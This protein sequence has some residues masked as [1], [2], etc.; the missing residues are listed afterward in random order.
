MNYFEIFDIPVSYGIDEQKITDVY[1]KKQQILHPDL[2]GEQNNSDVSMLNEA[3]YVLRNPIL[4]AGY[5]LKLKGIDPD[6]IV[7]SESAQEILLLREQYESIDSEIEIEDF[8]KYLRERMGNLIDS[9]Y[10]LENNLAE[11]NKKFTLLRFIKL[12]LDR[13]VPDAYCGD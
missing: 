8:S 5:F 11:F 3:Y 10:K 4:R 6:A 9:L 13:I 2:W 7:S 1:L 12:F